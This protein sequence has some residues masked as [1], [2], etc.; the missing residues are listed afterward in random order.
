MWSDLR[1]ERALRE[2][3]RIDDEGLD[4]LSLH[5]RA[6]EIVRSVVPFDGACVGAVDPDT[7]LLTSGVTVGFT[8]SDADNDRFVEIEF[9]GDDQ[10]SFASLA[11]RGVPVLADG[12][13]VPAYA[14]RDVRFN[15]LTRLIGFRHETRLT[16]TADGGCWAVGDL[17]R[18]DTADRFESRET[19][20]LELVTGRIGLATRGAVRRAASGSA[21]SPVGATVLLVAGDGRV[22]G[23]S[24]AARRWIDQHDDDARSR[25][26]FAITTAASLARRD[27][28]TPYTRLFLDSGW[29]IVHASPMD[30]GGTGTVAVTI[31]QAA[32]DV[33]VELLIAAHGL[34]PR[35]RDVCR[36]VLAGRSTQQIS[37][38][39]FIGGH[40]VQDHLKSIFDKLGVRSRREL[41]ATFG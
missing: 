5:S 3:E 24:E 30:L 37:D 20:F 25:L 26:G 14:R 41:V 16:F 12:G 22:V 6:L 28:E 27:V 18:A 4:L 23:V 9:G 1:A 15:E 21:P 34:S 10:G 32:P 2:L 17:Y 39:L 13:D 31:E 33:V 29:I 35:E 40:T 7:L 8:P 19:E 36:A 11:A 38:E